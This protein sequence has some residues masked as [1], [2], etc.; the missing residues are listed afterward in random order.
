ML[1]LS[2][3][4]RICGTTTDSLRNRTRDG[5]LPW[6]EDRREE[7]KHRRFHGEHALLLAIADCLVAQGISQG[8]AANVVRTNHRV[9]ARFLDEIAARLP[10]EERFI[11]A[12]KVCDETEGVGPAWIEVV[13]PWGGSADEIVGFVAKA[14][15]NA[16]RTWTEQGRIV[17]RAAGPMLAIAPVKECY[18]RVKAQAAAE[19]FRLEGRVI[20]K[21]GA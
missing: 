8:F 19:G 13:V 6:W 21:D 12:A 3:L 7:G 11:A 17:R 16:G 14:L 2:E 5:L 10:A 15:A 18:L 1:R 9:V 20:G 4:A